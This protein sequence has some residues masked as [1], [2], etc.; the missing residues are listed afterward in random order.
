[1]KGDTF[2]PHLGHCC[3]DKLPA[4]ITITLIFQCLRRSSPAI[5]D[6]MSQPR[7]RPCQSCTSLRHMS[8][9]G[10]NILSV[11]AMPFLGVSSLKDFRPPF[12]GHF[13]RSRRKYRSSRSGYQGLGVV[14]QLSVVK[15][16]GTWAAAD[17]SGPQLWPVTDRTRQAIRVFDVKMKTTDKSSTTALFHHSPFHQK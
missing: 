13:F 6:N 2:L 17:Q 9:Q 8:P 1:M 14:Q 5:P 12:G 3:P 10:R 4:S 7:Q 16:H 15:W 11:H